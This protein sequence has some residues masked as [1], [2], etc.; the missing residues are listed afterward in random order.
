MEAETLRL[1]IYGDP[2]LGVKAEKIS[3]VTERILDLGQKMIEIMRTNKGIGLAAPQIGISKRLIVLEL[4]MPGPDK[5]GVMPKLSPGEMLL[6]PQMPI[7]LINPVI[8]SANSTLLEAEEGCLSVP[9][10]YASLSRPT[11]VCLQTLT[12]SGESLNIQCGGWLARALQHE[13][14]HLDGVLFVDRLSKSCLR[15]NKI[16]LEKIKKNA[17]KNGFFKRLFK[18]EHTKEELF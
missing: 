10:F 2:V 5:D 16:K 4:S 17:L 9:D 12:T 13:I 8:T 15:D 14:D 1:R 18:N 7:L 11:E 6:V 3:K